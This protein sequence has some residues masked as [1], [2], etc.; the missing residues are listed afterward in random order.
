MIKNISADELKKWVESRKKVGIL[1]VRRDEECFTEHIEGALCVP[2][3][4]LEEVKSMFDAK[5][6]LVVYCSDIK[7]N[8]SLYAAERLEE[9]GFSEVYELGGGL[10]E[11]KRETHPH[12]EHFIETGTETNIE[13]I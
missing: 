7:C 6:P 10:E 13:G 8:S 2:M 5:T 11:W 4:R 1:D 12:Q 9:L 3:N